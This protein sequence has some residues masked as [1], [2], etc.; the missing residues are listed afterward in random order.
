MSEMVIDTLLLALLNL[1]EPG[2][3]GSLKPTCVHWQN[4][5]LDARTAVGGMMV[6][7]ASAQ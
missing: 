3:E 1:R 6:S 7:T 4:A 2:K 5:V